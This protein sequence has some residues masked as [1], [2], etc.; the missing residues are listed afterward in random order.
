MEVT[1]VVDRARSEDGFGLMSTLVAMVLLA[2]AVTALS[3][4]AMMSVAVHTDSSVRATAT[5]IGASYLEEVK[6]RP[7]KTVASE[8]AVKVNGL[9][10]DDPNG[11]FERT[12]EV[13]PEEDLPYTKRLAVSVVYPSGKGRTGTLRLET[14][15]YEGEN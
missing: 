13:T 9:G 2:I 14:V 6:A 11:R 7:P 15:Y 8:A 1:R 12:L 5:A 3:S 10:M 4:S